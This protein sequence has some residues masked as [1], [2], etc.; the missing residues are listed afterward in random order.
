[1]TKKAGF[2]QNMYV[3][4]YVHTLFLIHYIKPATQHLFSV[5][6]RRSSKL[7]SDACGELPFSKFTC[8]RMDDLSFFRNTDQGDQVSW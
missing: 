6:A 3:H 8:L 4:G 2:V 1:M 5:L 7:K